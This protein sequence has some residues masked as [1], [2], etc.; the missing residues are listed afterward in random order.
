VILFMQIFLAHLLGDFVF[1]SNSLLKKKY[2]SWVGTAEHASIIA[3]LTALFLFPYWFAWQTWAIVFCIWGVHFTQDVLKVEYDKRFNANLSTAPYFLDQMGHI[4]LMAFLVWLFPV[5]QNITLPEGLHAFYFS[6]AFLFLA[7]TFV[8]LSFVYDITLYQFYHKK[9][10][11]QEY[12]PDVRGMAERM[13]SF[14]VFVLIFLF[15]HRLYLFT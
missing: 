9:H 1:Q 8:F 13:V 3:F 7:L 15:L 2:H 12:V 11:Q 4:A 14:L 10:P 5:H 6:P